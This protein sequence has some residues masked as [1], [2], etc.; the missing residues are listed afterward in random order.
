MLETN[1]SMLCEAIVALACEDYVNLHERGKTF[2]GTRQSGCFS[3]DEIESFL[4]SDW[5][6]RLLSAINSPIDGETILYQLKKNVS[7]GKKLD[8]RSIDDVIK[9]KRE[10]VS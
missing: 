8:I 9:E 3:I 6:N 5:C 2:V 10:L 7:Q 4:H 1:I